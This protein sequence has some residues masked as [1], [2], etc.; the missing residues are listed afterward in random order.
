MKTKFAPRA[1]A[2]ALAALAALAA[3]AAPDYSWAQR[4]GAAPQEQPKPD[5]RRGAM[6]TRETEVRGA[7]GQLK[8][9]ADPV[10]V[11]AEASAAVSASGVTCAVAD[12]AL[13]GTSAVTVDGAPITRNV[14]EVS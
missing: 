10:K 12:A 6:I 4:R 11:K 3:G 5:R 9:K 8:E 1:A 7:D 13:R 14:Y 2:L